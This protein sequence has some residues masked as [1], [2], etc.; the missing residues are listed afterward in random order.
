MDLEMSG[1]LKLTSAI[2]FNYVNALCSASHEPYKVFQKSSL[3]P[4]YY[5]SDFLFVWKRYNN[6]G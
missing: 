5:S 3:I 6:L 1:T 2:D 4:M